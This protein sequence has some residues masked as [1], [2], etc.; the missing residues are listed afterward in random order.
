M[1]PINYTVPATLPEGTAGILAIINLLRHQDAWEKSFTWKFDSIYETDC[2]G[3]AGCA[4]G[5]VCHTYFSQLRFDLHSLQL[6][7]RKQWAVVADGDTA[8]I[9]ALGLTDE[10]AN[11]LLWAFGL[12]YNA[13]SDEPYGGKPFRDVTPGNVADLLTKLLDQG[14]FTFERNIA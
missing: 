11:W 2:C 9:K 13:M 10:G 5:L 12:D 6:G 4:L 8:L 1:K 7:F 3:T 14:K